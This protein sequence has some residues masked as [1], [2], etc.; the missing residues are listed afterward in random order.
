MWISIANEF[1]KFHSIRLHLSENIP[2]S[3]RAATF[4][5]TACQCRQPSISK[6]T[7]KN[8]G[9]RPPAEIA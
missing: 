1:A 9:S 7:L 2:K 3:F 5:E 4:S 6:S 8:V